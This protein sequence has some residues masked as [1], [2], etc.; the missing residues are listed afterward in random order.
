MSLTS[1][2]F[3]FFGALMIL[4][5]ASQWYMMRSITQDVSTELGKV[6]FSVAKDTASFFVLGDFQWTTS[7]N[8]TKST[9]ENGVEVTQVEQFIS[10]QTPITRQLQVPT[11][12]IR[13][14]NQRTDN[15]IELITSTNTN[16]IPLPR[17]DMI[18]TVEK[19]ENQMLISSSIILGIGLLIAAVVT[20][21][22]MSPLKALT[23]A[24]ETVSAGELGTQI[25]TSTQRSLSPEIQTSI[26]T[27]ND[28]SANLKAMQRKN[29]ELQENAHYQELGYI[30]SGL[31]HSIRNPLNTLT[32]SLDQIKESNA[33]DNA[34]LY[35]TAHRQIQRIND[36]VKTF[37]TFS[38]GAKA[39]TSHVN[40]AN[41]LQ[42]I[43]LEA[44]QQ[45]PD[46]EFKINMSDNLSID[47][48]E[49]EIHAMLHS[50]VI[51]AVE[52]SPEGGQIKIDVQYHDDNLQAI[53]IDQGAGMSDDTL[54]SLFQP[55]RSTKSK[56]TGM[57]LYLAQKLA[58]NR[59]Q[60]HIEC[61]NSD[62]TGTNICLT[63][64]TSRKLS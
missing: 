37:M 48:I 2:V 14:D 53:I 9:N 51:N 45:R 1:R 59:Y 36:W 8:I 34:M 19:L 12:E 6:A 15:F 32:L 46:V 27:F 49:A 40:I 22:L 24:A 35:A 31:A 55:F 16:K 58:T 50:I 61:L 3:A 18:A 63:I 56:G 28:M 42:A 38:M 11:V 62:N 47:G 17:E 10:S 64:N 13:I 52:A 41:V 5:V 4:L 25:D 43:Q 60:G 54:A 26:N 7:R 20:R 30:S 39:E 29:T 33:G 21:R 44:T 57:G 23:Q